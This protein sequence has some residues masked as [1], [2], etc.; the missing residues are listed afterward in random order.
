MVEVVRRNLLSWF[1]YTAADAITGILEFAGI[2]NILPCGSQASSRNQK[3]ILT[4]PLSATINECAQN[5]FMIGA[6]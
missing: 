3:T 5:N 4:L 2:S 6:N 1:W